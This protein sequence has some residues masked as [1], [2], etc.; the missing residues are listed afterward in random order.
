[1][2]GFVTHHPTCIFLSEDPNGA[3]TLHTEQGTRSVNLLSETVSDHIPP[4]SNAQS[5]KLQVEN[6]RVCLPVN[7]VQVP[8]LI[9]SFYL[10]QLRVPNETDTTYWCVSTNFS[11]PVNEKIYIYK[12]ETS[13]VLSMAT[14]CVC[15]LLLLL[16]LLLVLLLLFCSH[17][18]ICIS[19]NVIFKLV[20]VERLLCLNE[21]HTFVVWSTYS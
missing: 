11:T 18:C 6:V 12:V 17:L 16:F 13:S 7:F 1:M 3:F 5:F 19:W 9:C 20:Q 15:L 2:T 14:T 21:L 10:P 4:S 8:Y